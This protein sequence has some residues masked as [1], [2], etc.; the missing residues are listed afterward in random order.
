MLIA[1]SGQFGQIAGILGFELRP[2]I[3]NIGASQAGRQQRRTDS[4]DRTEDGDSTLSRA[5]VIHK[6]GLCSSPKYTIPT[7]SKCSGERHGQI[8]TVVEP[9][10]DW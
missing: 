10:G 8:A 5:T 9:H 7:G 4:N 6:Q 1:P 2:S 3:G